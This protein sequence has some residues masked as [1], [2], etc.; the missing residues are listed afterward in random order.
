MKIIRI[1]Y[2]DPKSGTI[3]TIRAL[4]IR[5]VVLDPSFIDG[6]KINLRPSQVGILWEGF[7]GQS[8]T[9]PKSDVILIS[10]TED[11]YDLQA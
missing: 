1:V 5:E 3:Q 9:I 7:N 11:P 2:K 6:N 10:E 4:R 8:G